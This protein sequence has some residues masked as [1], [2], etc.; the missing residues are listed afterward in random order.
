MQQQAHIGF[1]NSEI[2]QQEI[3][4]KIEIELEKSGEKER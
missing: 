2:D 4:R 3:R 1:G